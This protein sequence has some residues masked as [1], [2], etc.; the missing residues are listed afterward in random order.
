MVTLAPVAVDGGWKALY[1]ANRGT[2]ANA[3]LI[4]VGQVIRLPRA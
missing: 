3:N 4:Y 2:V 1:A